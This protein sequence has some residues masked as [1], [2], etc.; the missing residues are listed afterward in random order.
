MRRR[1]SQ[2]LVGPAQLAD[3]TLL[4]FST[5]PGHRSSTPAAGP[6]PVPLAAPNVGAFPMNPRSSRRRTGSR[7]IASRAGLRARTP[8]GPLALKPLVSICSVF[9]WAPSSQEMEPSGK[10][11]TVQQSSAGRKRPRNFRL[12]G[13]RTARQW[14]ADRG[15]PRR[16]ASTPPASYSPPACRTRPRH[17]PGSETVGVS[18]CGCPLRYAVQSSIRRRRCSKRS[19]R[20]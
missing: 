16:M 9:P 13:F 18:D 17:S 1:L 20:A 8:S 14:R 19:L 10:P 11:G 15:A 12:E 4:C 6:D 2:D 7:P 5:A 3:F